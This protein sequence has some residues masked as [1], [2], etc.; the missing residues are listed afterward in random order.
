MPNM[1]P[2]SWLPLCDDEG[3]FISTLWQVDTERNWVREKM[4]TILFNSEEFRLILDLIVALVDPTFSF[5]LEVR[6]Q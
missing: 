6:L 4:A 3:I 5:M 2:D 1:E